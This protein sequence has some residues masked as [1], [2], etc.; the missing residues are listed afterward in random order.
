M[1]ILHIYPGGIYLGA[2]SLQTLFRIYRTQ[3][4][5]VVREKKTHTNLIC[6]KNYLS[7]T[8]FDHRAL[9]DRNV[10]LG[11]TLRDYVLETRQFFAEE[12]PQ[13]ISIRKRRKQQSFAKMLMKSIF[14]SYHKTCVSIAIIPVVLSLHPG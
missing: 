9:R 1:Y 8:V 14:R 7:Q 10:T 12:N 11:L 13:I 4:I 2:E 5:V 3:I 6:C